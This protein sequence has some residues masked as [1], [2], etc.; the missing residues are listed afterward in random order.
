MG[1]K[2]RISSL[3]AL[4]EDLHDLKSKKLYPKF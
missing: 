1:G 3:E 4:A 2:R